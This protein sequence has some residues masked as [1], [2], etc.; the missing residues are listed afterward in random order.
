MDFREGF[1][2]W[3]GLGIDYEGGVLDVAGRTAVHV[4]H[5]M[6]ALI[7]FLVVSSIAISALLTKKKNL[8]RTGLVVVLVLFAQVSLGIANVLLVLPL[9][10][11]VAHNGVAAL[12][13]LSL[14]TLLYFSYSVNGKTEH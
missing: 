5:R 3:R 4:S 11:A 1:K 2:L 12:L 6:G 9:P 13:L 10:V 7:T 8:M 14:I